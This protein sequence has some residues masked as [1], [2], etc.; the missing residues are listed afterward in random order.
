MAFH[1][2][3]WF[4]RFAGHRSA[5]PPLDVLASSASPKDTLGNRLNWL[6]DVLQWIRRP[7]HE[8]E[9]PA[10]PEINIQTG[11]LRRL[12]DVLDRNPEWKKSVAQTFR[13]II[14]ETSAL[15]L[16]S[17]TG[18]PRQFGMLQEISG[19]LAKKW[20][21]SSDSAE[22]GVLFDRLFPHPQ[23]S[24]W[25]EKLDDQTLLR[26]RDLLEFEVGDDEKNWNSLSAELE[27]ALFHLA[28]QLN[29]SGCSAAIRMRVK[30]RRI[31]EL[32]FFNLHSALQSVLAARQSGV[33]SDFLAELNNLH[34][35]IESCHR[36]VEEATKHLENLGVSTEVVY[37]LAFIEASLE[38][39]KTL[40]ELNFNADLPLTRVASF[41]ATLVRKNRARES[42]AEFLRQNF[43][44]LTRKILERNGETGEHYIAR[45]PK[46]Y[47][48]MLRSAAGGG[49]IMAFTTWF[50]LIILGWHLPALMEGLAASTNYAA[51][52]V[53]IQLS[54]STLATKQPANTGPALAAR[55]HHV[56]E[57]DA[58]ESLVNEIVFLI[59][60]QFASIVGN[61]AL[62]VPTMLA[63]Y[64]MVLWC[65]GSPLM[66]DEKAVKSIH[67]LSLFGPTPFYAAFTGVLLWASSMIAAWTDNWFA[68]HRLGEA[69]AADRRLVR[70]LG[71][72]RALR[73][74]TFFKRNIGGLAGN[75][76]FG[77]ML[78]LI[79][80]IAAF[81][82]IP[83]DIRH[84]TLSS[85]MLTTAGATLGL[86]VLSTA[87]FWL[88]VLGVI[89]IACMNLTVSFSL[90][91]FVAIRARDIESPERHAIYRTLWKRLIHEPLSFILPISSQTVT[92]AREEKLAPKA[93]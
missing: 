25:L 31:S 75:I 8:D 85:G 38:R 73:L 86:S 51:G 32:P 4:D 35:Q 81:A 20:L 41:V 49:V 47:R 53:G 57:P 26:V 84:V 69:L 50:K 11:R 36:A 88:A 15:E 29:V 66:N 56:R 14:R 67:S 12:L 58:M 52:F 5:L 9:L 83:L 23:D 70:G 80:E 43:H 27:G 42:V 64:F 19:R 24:A 45:T 46:E 62:I 72:S 59:R 28:A 93:T 92:P 54:G 78:G 60:S 89:G 3:N 91:L 13:S 55:M 17:E 82:G 63:I 18:L 34:A 79:P 87:P 2:K 22:L 44:L 21:P 37:Q 74:G 7:G 16:F 90:A 65:T 76:S 1:L 39:F 10:A 71:T 68:C 48:E 6:V 40:L 61:I 33:S 30:H 77:F